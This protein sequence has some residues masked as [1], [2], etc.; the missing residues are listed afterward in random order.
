MIVKIMNKAVQAGYFRRLSDS[1][2]SKVAVDGERFVYTETNTGID[3]I[4]DASR[5]IAA[6]QT[7]CQSTK[8]SKT[9][10]I[11]VSFPLGELPTKDQLRDIELEL[12]KSIGFEDHHRI[13]AVHDDASHLHMHLAISRI[14]PETNRNISPSYSKLKLYAKARELEEKHNLLPLHAKEKEEQT[15]SANARNYEAV[16]GNTSFQSWS[17]ESYKQPLKE[18]LFDDPSWQ[19]VHALLAE[20]GVKIKRKGRGMVFVDETE[21]HAVKPSTLDRSFS[22]GN[23]EK[24][25]GPLVITKP[26][27]VQRSSAYKK[28][29]NIFSKGEVSLY[30]KYKEGQASRAEF[31]KKSLVELSIQRGK[32]VKEIKDFFNKKRISIWK[33]KAIRTQDKYPTVKK[34]TLQKKRC[35][36]DVYEKYA[37]RRSMIR[38]ENRS[39]TWKEYL[40]FEASKG[41]EKAIVALRRKRKREEH[42]TGNI[43]S[44]EEKGQNKLFKMKRSVQKN[45]D[46]CYTVKDSFVDNGKSISM[47]GYDIDSIREAI[48]VAK[49][50]YGR[51]LKVEGD[52]RF[53]KVVHHLVEAEKSLGVSIRTPEETEELQ[54]QLQ[55]VE[56]EK[57]KLLSRRLERTE[58]EWDEIVD[59]KFKEI[60]RLQGIDLSFKGPYEKKVVQDSQTIALEKS[61]QAHPEGYEK[62]RRLRK[63]VS[64]QLESPVERAEA[65]WDNAI[66]TECEKIVAVT[67]Q[68]I[69]K[70]KKELEENREERQEH[71]QREPRQTVF[72]F[73]FEKKYKEWL[74]KRKEL[75]DQERTLRSEIENKEVHTHGSVLR[76]Y[77]T[78]IQRLAE[79]RSREAHPELHKDLKRLRLREPIQSLPAEGGYSQREQKAIR[80]SVALKIKIERLT[81]KIVKLVSDTNDARKDIQDNW[82]KYDKQKWNILKTSENMMLE[83][84]DTQLE[85]EINNNI[86]EHQKLMEQLNKLKKDYHKNCFCPMSKPIHELLENWQAKSPL[87]CAEAEWKYM[88]DKYSKAIVAVVQKE[89]EKLEKKLKENEKEQQ[90]HKQREPQQTLFSFGFEK[91]Y[92]EWY[93]EGLKLDSEEGNIIDEIWEL[94]EYSDGEKGEELV[95]EKTTEARSDLHKKIKELKEEQR[96]NLE[97]ERE[98][99]RKEK[100]RYSRGRGRDFG[101]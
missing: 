63:A 22:R 34:S 81:K 80:A 49:Q 84:K 6:G 21:K 39:L 8:A 54:A 36:Q 35:L 61:I 23:M 101:R 31:K 75:N 89:T 99:E 56:K 70:L 43:I 20:Y 30:D 68:E 72:T 37:N 44:G 50:Q 32:E 95:L 85:F 46:V 77:P 24:L 45:G 4:K 67:Q 62:L 26:L 10:H 59:S 82:E 1:I 15:I 25:L 90:E 55:Q 71:K 60:V 98:L 87:E 57:K 17:V 65:K 27:G 11:V 7:K 69:G 18:L 83:K 96:E 100:Y 13:S 5:Y 64:Q 3:D 97:R 58:T 48:L 79:E 42:Q 52:E 29:P 91:K 12:C 53:L 2:T 92:E 28:Q 88:K 40:V 33:S 66:Y 74:I 76:G 93:E 14:H 86:D 41:N 94:K 73:G 78:N 38:Q 9:M 47:Q 16:T 19:K 51:N